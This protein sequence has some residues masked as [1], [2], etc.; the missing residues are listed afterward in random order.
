MIPYRL[1]R[2]KRKTVAILIT[3]DAQ[4]EVRAPMRTPASFIEHFLTEK[5]LWIEKHL[6]H[7]QEELAIQQIFSV[8]EGDCL[9]LLGREYPV[10]LSS[11]YTK[12][13]Y[14]GNQ[15]ILPLKE[16]SENKPLLVD[17]YRHLAKNYITEKVRFYSSLMNVK[18]S[19]VK[20]GSASTRW[21]SCSGKNSLNFT[22]KL[23][24]APEKAVDYVVVHELCHIF[25]HNHSARFWKE[26]QRVLPDYRER[27]ELLRQLQQKLL[28]EGW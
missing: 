15:F 13:I 22:W 20:I 28:R 16:F 14:N 6:A 21:G 17:L 18:P 23:I 10:H 27:E 25:Q 4:V 9:M 7:R 2:S 24:L 5:E 19:A 12:P 11:E 3:K 1:I 8:G 26:V